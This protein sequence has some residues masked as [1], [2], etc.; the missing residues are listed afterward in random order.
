MAQTDMNDEARSVVEL[1]AREIRLAGYNPRCILTPTAGGG[2]RSRRRRRPP[3]FST[4]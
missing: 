2:D 1:M 4:I 3:R